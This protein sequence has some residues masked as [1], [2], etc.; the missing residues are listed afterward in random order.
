MARVEEGYQNDGG[1]EVSGGRINRITLG[2]AKVILAG[3]YA[4][5]KKMARLVSLKQSRT[6]HEHSQGCYIAKW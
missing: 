6:G 4:D 2:N 1:Y 3:E 5:D